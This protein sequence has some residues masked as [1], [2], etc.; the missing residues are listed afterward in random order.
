[1]SSTSNQTM[2]RIGAD[3]LPVRWD[4]VSLM[5]HDV[6]LERPDESGYLVPGS[7]QYKLTVE[8][9]REH[10][11]TIAEL[12]EHAPVI[13]FDS[14]R[15]G[16]AS[17]TGG[18]APFALTFDD[19]GSSAY[20]IIAPMLEE[21]GW[22]GH[23]F[24]ATEHLGTERFITAQQA[25]ELHARGH[26][27]GSHSHSHPER[28]SS[29]DPASQVAEWATSTAALSELLGV[30]VEVASVPNGYYTPPVARAAAQAGIRLLFTSEPTVRSQ[31]VAGCTVAGRFSIQRTTSSS[32]VAALVG[33]NPLYRLRQ[34][35][36]WG[37]KKAMKRVGGEFYLKARDSI[38]RRTD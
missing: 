14:T 34:G 35:Y 23:F 6:I 8:R 17:A 32:V 37:A 31:Q 22:R 18:V 33:A 25:I 16:S 36:A 28:F 19:G 27:I 7:A 20:S 1:M 2:T 21:F 3:G 11:V 4:A 12:T 15:A 38:L 9:F 10:L 5:Y 30:A 29:L 13:A 26:V 24:V